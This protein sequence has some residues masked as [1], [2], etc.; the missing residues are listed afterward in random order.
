M[1][2]K[3]TRGGSGGDGGGSF[4]PSKNNLY[5]AVKEIFHPTTN[6]GVDADD[7]NRELDVSGGGGS[8]FTPS[9]SNIYDAVKE[10]FHP[11]TNSGVSADDTNNELDVSGGTA[12][13]LPAADEDTVGGVEAAD[14]T[15][16][17]A[18]SGT[19]VLG[20]SNNRIRALITAALP[21]I[22]AG[23]ATAGTST[24]RRV[25][26][27]A[28]VRSAI[29]QVVPTVFRSGNTDTITTAKL[30][31]GTR[32]GSTYLK[33]DGTFGAVTP[34]TG[35]PLN[36]LALVKVGETLT[37]SSSAAVTGP[38]YSDLSDVFWLSWVYTRST[39]TAVRFNTIV[40]KAEVEGVASGS[41][42]RLQL[43]GGGGA[44]ILLYDDSSNFTIGALDSQYSAGSV[45]VYKFTGSEDGITMTAGDA[46]YLQLSG[47]TLTGLLTLS[48]APTAD[49][50]AA[51]KKY[52]DDNAG[53]G[54]SNVPDSP[55]AE[56]AVTKYVLNVATDGTATWVED[57]GG[58]S[59]SNVPDKPSTPS[60]DTVYNLQ[61]QSD[62]TAA[63]VE[64]TGGSGGSSSG[65]EPT[66]VYDSGSFANITGDRWS[67]ATFSEAF[68]DTDQL[69]FLFQKRFGASPPQGVAETLAQ[70]PWA[71][72]VESD[73]TTHTSNADQDGTQIV[74]ENLDS[75]PND[76]ETSIVLRKR[77]DGSLG[78]LFK[79]TLSTIR[80]RIYKAPLGG[81]SG[82]GD[83]DSEEIA[84]LEGELVDLGE[85]VDNFDVPESVGAYAD[86]TASEL[87][88][89]YGVF[90]AGVN[91]YYQDSDFVISKNV[92]TETTFA[93]L[94]V[95]IPK[96]RSRYGVR[97]VG[98]GE[99]LPK[100]DAAEFEHLAPVSRDTV[101]LAQDP[102]LF[103]G[104]PSEI[105]DYYYVAGIH[106]EGPISFLNFSGTYK[107]QIAPVHY[108]QWTYIDYWQDENAAPRTAA[109]H[110]RATTSRTG[111]MIPIIF[112]AKDRPRN[113]HF[114]IPNN[115]EI[116]DIIMEGSSVIGDFTSRAFNN[117]STA[118]D[119]ARI[120]S[121]NELTCMIKLERT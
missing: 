51:T 36:A 101:G 58:G 57:T 31:T 68:T 29:N 118:Y 73:A 1:P 22:S 25:W 99:T 76:N 15:Q 111:V 37:L 117:A 78:Y 98:G 120:R 44:F 42:Y 48:G 24:A 106:N 66:E 97:I 79:D 63:W 16:A 84:A 39:G 103:S 14:A 18:A 80:V 104:E 82:G 10:I 50:H 69:I 61:I 108:P 107:L 92:P 49:L 83:G 7:T 121:A 100:T 9:K 94:Y 116:T 74:V 35:G 88:E 71:L 87:A 30:G 72:I 113:L 93:R 11:S 91:G 27:S 109:G 56:S 77:T 3:F 110:A 65:A 52:V 23:D 5:N 81:G 55:S 32:D 47:G 26:T 46:R 112:A 34:S 54:G 38:A 40:R 8:S 59:G 67:E 17:S 19:T 43:Q 33:G 28:R 41:A 12:Y 96:H 102:P 20:W 6:S 4:T 114:L 53:G 86:A 64:D 13:T 85:Q 21:T 45:D 90:F 62:G 115:F 75:I 70:V 2:I 89:G 60:N 119:S 105:A 95:R